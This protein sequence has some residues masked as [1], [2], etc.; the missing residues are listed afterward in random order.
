MLKD[1]VNLVTAVAFH[2]CLVLHAAF[3]QPG[4]HHLA[5]PSI[6]LRQG[7]F[8]RTA[9]RTGRATHDMRLMERPS[10]A[11][12]SPGQDGGHAPKLPL[13]CVCTSS[14]AASVRFRN[15]H[16]T[17]RLKCNVSI[18]LGVSAPESC[19]SAYNRCRRL[20]IK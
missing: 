7:K 16:N 8:D 13:I 12:S 4:D 14:T 3:T 11:S 2:F 9:R 1:L 19:Y 15:P 17:N 18:T 6:V 5:K 20:L 10:T